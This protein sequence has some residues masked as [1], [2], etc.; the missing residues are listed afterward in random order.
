MKRMLFWL[1]MVCLI[2]RSPAAD[3]SPQSGSN[4]SSP[5]QPAQRIYIDP[6]TGRPGVPPPGQVLQP[7]ITNRFS[8]SSEGL[9]EVP[10]TEKPGGFKVHLGGRFQSTIT[11]SN[12]PN[13]KTALHCAEDV[14]PS[15]AKP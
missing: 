1:G 5:Q 13:G 6:A 15:N 14:K 3:S 10:V 12:S 2:A 7:A 9:K 4:P 8:T 11:A